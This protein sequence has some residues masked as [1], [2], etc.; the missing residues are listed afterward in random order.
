[1]NGAW[2]RRAIAIEAAILALADELRVQERSVWC[3]VYLALIGALDGGESIL[4]SVVVHGRPELAHAEKT[5]G[6]FL[7][8][9]PIHVKARGC[10][11]AEFIVRVDERLQELQ[12]HRHYPLAQIQAELHL[13]FSASLFNFVNFHVLSDSAEHSGV[14]GI[15]NGLDDTDYSFEVDVVKEEAAS[16]HFFRVTLDPAIFDSDQIRHHVENIIAAMTR[17]RHEKIVYPGDQKTAPNTL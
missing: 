17:N 7:N 16:R 1:M 9:L 10:T 3:A 5:M 6:M 8:L 2:R 15:G 14:Q 11:W 4:G 13:D 12:Q